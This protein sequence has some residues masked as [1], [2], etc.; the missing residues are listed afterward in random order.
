[1]TEKNYNP[2]QKERNSMK[3]QPKKRIGNTKKLKEK[4]IKMEENKKPKIENT[5]KETETNT[6]STLTPKKI[7]EENKKE[8]KEEPKEIEKNKKEKKPQKKIKKTEVHVYGK[9]LPVS[10][11][12]SI[13]ICKF[14]KNKK[15]EEA[16]IDLS[17]VIK[18]KKAVP[19]KGEIPHQK[20]KGMMS[21]RFP[22]RAS[23]YFINL[24]KSLS[25]NADNH[26]VENPIITKAIANLSQRPFGRFGKVK[27][28]RTHI[29]LEAQDKEFIIK[30]KNK[31]ENEKKQESKK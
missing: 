6:S 22:K 19:M 1:M 13:A 27:R 16:I 11:K 3:K 23:G 31:K 5:K 12:Y 24:L 4:K 29:Y 21:G 20:G 26:E 17:Q 25:S 30:K 2:K 10:M 15:I 9:S 7:E 8:T 18:L 14:I 28:K